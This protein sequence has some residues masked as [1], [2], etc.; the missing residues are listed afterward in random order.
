MKKFLVIYNSTMS[1][2]Q[3]MK[4]ATPEQA[5][6]GMDAWMEWAGKAGPAIVDLGSP[7]GPAATFEAPGTRTDIQSE[8]GGYSVLQAESMDALSKVLE[9]HPHFMMPGASIRVHELLPLPGM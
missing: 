5:K 4:S 7:V 3:Q 8:A 1:A 2:M 6:A 9:G